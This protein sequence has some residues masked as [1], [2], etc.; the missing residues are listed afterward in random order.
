[1]NA[2]QSKKGYHINYTTG[3]LK[4]KER[5][6]LLISCYQSIFLSK[7]FSYFFVIILLV[8]CFYVCFVLCRCFRGERMKIIEKWHKKKLKTK[9]KNESEVGTSTLELEK[10][11]S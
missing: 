8:V 2:S 11:K 5:S 6:E 1:M 7:I 4:R 9:A 10:K 3:Y